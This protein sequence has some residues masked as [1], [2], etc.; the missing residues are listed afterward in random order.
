MKRTK[1]WWARLTK[2]ERGYLV[3]L[4]K[5]NNQY[6]GYGGGGYL[7]DDCS[8]CTAC[9]QPMLGSGLCTYCSDNLYRLIDKGNGKI[10]PPIVPEG[11]Q[12]EFDSLHERAIAEAE[13][14]S[15]DE[16]LNDM[17]A[18]LRNGG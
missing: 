9:G 11:V 13:A 15:E 14:V 12:E 10:E 4:E 1:E 3:Y 16:S 5:A 2:D 7:P 18:S 17:F 8:E 6:G